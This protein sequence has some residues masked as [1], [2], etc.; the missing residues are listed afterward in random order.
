VITCSDSRVPVVWTSGGQLSMGWL[1]STLRYLSSSA[2]LNA[3]Q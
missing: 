3:V 2:T 1:M